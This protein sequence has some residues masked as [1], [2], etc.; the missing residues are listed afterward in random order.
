MLGFESEHKVGLYFFKTNQL[1]DIKWGTNSAIK[2][3][4][5]KYKF[6]V[7]LRAFG[8][9][10]IQI[11]DPEWFFVNLMGSR[12]QLMIGDIRDLFVSRFIQPMTDYF[13]NAKYSYAEID[14][15]RLEISTE[16]L[17]KI[18]KDFGQLGFVLQDFR[19][20][21]T[22][23]DDDTISRINR[24]S[25]VSADTQAANLAGLSYSQL[26]QLQALKE[27]AKNP[28]GIGVA[29]GMGLGVGFGQQT[30]SAIANTVASAGDEPGLRLKKV[31]DLL[32]QGLISQEEFEQKKKE[33]LSKI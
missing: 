19:I 31:K 20:E 6:P 24:I 15:H 7:G 13:A 33:I 26:Q 17:T 5:P 11:E 21:G 25:D 27:A 29:M 23:F 14:S 28:G 30:Q 16:I 18:Q 22:S 4:D 3:E 32:D 8:N 2:Y 9:F 1:A 12:S 10:S